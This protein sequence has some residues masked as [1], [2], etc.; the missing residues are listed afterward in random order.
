MAD[1]KEV[2]YYFKVEAVEIENW[3]RELRPE[4]KKIRIKGMSIILND[5]IIDLK[6]VGLNYYF[7]KIRKVPKDY[8]IK[9]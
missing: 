3:L 8:K 5:E 9:E 4:F 6:K 1:K 7:D 2:D